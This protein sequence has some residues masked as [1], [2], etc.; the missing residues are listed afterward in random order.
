MMKCS[1]CG[2]DVIRTTHSIYRRDGGSSG[3]YYCKDCEAVKKWS[4]PGHDEKDEVIYMGD[5]K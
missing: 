1:I 4:I 5:E 3:E 2:G